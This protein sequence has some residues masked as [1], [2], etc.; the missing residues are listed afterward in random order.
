[1]MP[2]NL[3]NITISENKNV[4]YCSIVSGI[5]KTETISLLQNI[6]L[7]GKSGTL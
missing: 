3:S 2:M 7:V 4:D 1:M 5:S 6:D